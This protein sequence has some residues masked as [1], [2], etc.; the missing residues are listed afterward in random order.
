VVSEPA[1]ILIEKNSGYLSEMR[2]DFRQLTTDLYL[3]VA[4]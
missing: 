1:V 3:L 4:E 2:P